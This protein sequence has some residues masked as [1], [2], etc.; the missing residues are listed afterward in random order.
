[1]EQEKKCENCKFFVMHYIL[2][3]TKFMPLSEGHCTHS[4]I[5]W[6]IRKYNMPCGNCCDKWERAED[7]KKKREESIKTVLK[8]MR[9]S[10]KQIENILSDDL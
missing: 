2:H 6:K 8:S 7:K 10:L 4:E 3:S 1:M 9:S 5:P